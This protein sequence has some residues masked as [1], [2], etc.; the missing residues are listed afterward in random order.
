M[1]KVLIQKKAKKKK[2][3]NIKS[4]DDSDKYLKEEEDI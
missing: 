3:T 2:E 1:Q 4:V